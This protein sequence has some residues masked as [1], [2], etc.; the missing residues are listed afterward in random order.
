M[1]I[2]H[3]IAITVPEFGHLLRLSVSANPTL[4]SIPTLVEM[5]ERLKLALRASLRHPPVEQAW[6]NVVIRGGAVLAMHTTS[7]TQMLEATLGTIIESD[8][9]WIDELGAEIEDTGPHPSIVVDL[10]DAMLGA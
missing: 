9:R 5:M 2:A 8:V 7:P 6:S 4:A 3:D 1:P 10:V